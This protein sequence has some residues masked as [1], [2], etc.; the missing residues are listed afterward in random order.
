MLQEFC[1]KTGKKVDILSYDILDLKNIYRF[2]EDSILASFHKMND[3]II[4][5]LEMVRSYKEFFDNLLYRSDVWNT[6]VLL[7][8]TPVYFKLYEGLQEL[9]P[10][11]GGFDFKQFYSLRSGNGVTNLTFPLLFDQFAQ[12]ERVAEFYYRYVTEE[13]NKLGPSEKITGLNLA[14]SE[15][16]RLKSLWT[17]LYVAGSVESKPA[18]GAV[19]EINFNEEF[20]AE[21]KTDFG[22]QISRM[23]SGVVESLVGNQEQGLL[24][25]GK[26]D[27]KKFYILLSVA[28]VVKDYVDFIFRSVYEVKANILYADDKSSGKGIRDLFPL[29]IFGLI[30]RKYI[31]S[32]LV[33][34]TRKVKYS[35]VRLQSVVSYD[36]E[37]KIY[38]LQEDVSDETVANTT[39]HIYSCLAKMNCNLLPYKD[40][41]SSEPEARRFMLLVLFL[42]FKRLID[43]NDFIGEKI[44]S[45]LEAISSL[46]PLLNEKYYYTSRMGV[47]VLS[48]SYKK[49]V[50]QFVEGEKEKIFNAEITN[51]DRM[52]AMYS[53]TN[54]LP[55]FADSVFVNS[56]GEWICNMEILISKNKRVTKYSILTVVGIVVVTD[57]GSGSY[58]NIILRE[59]DDTDR[60]WILKA[61]GN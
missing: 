56:G 59:Y 12:K 11:G 5:S 48:D 40:E 34:L 32:N 31:Y 6:L 45:I 15:I 14:D 28:K 52:E 4:A 25:E 21:K 49:L 13:I 19:S 2:D 22:L 16:K 10:N 36:S 1:N 44:K 53:I 61:G 24:V 41:L 17:P 33:S 39:Y 35:Y 7:Y 23:L 57:D 30:S 26:S 42:I 18:K 60:D 55:L 46:E 50:L 20:T 8:K 37:R 58:E 29:E 43:F 47:V 38:S 54:E 9:V 51:F 3:S 27:C